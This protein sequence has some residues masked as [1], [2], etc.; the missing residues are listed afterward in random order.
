[1]AL[2]HILFVQRSQEQSMVYIWATPQAFKSPSLWE[3]W[4]NEQIPVAPGSPGGTIERILQ[5]PAAG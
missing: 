3:P 1:M 4:N 5:D 2:W